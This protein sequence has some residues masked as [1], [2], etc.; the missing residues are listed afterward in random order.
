[1]KTIKAKVHRLPTED[2]TGLWKLTD[3]DGNISL[4]YSMNQKKRSNLEGFHLYI[5]TDEEIKDGDWVYRPYSKKVSQVVKVLKTNRGLELT[6]SDKLAVI[7][8]DERKIIATTDHL[9]IP[10][11]GMMSLQGEWIP[12]IPQS[13]IEEYCKVGGIDEVLVEYTSDEWSESIKLQMISMGDNPEDFKKD[14]ELKLNSNNEIIIHPVE[15]KMYSRSELENVMGLCYEL[16][17]QKGTLND[18]NRL[19]QDL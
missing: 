3:V 4:H 17:I 18:L 11:P 10:T 13:F 2:E 8:S 15:E 5:T 19:K 12:K 14:S 9:E 16:G 1:M 7:L 6:Y